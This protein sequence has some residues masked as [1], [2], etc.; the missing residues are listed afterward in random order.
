MRNFRLGWEMGK[1]PGTGLGN[2][3][4]PLFPS[5]I[6]NHSTLCIPSPQI[7]L[8]SDNATAYFSSPTSILYFSSSLFT[9]HVA[10]WLHIGSTHPHLAIVK[11]S[12][13]G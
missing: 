11:R 1:I 3:F 9:H 4:P 13:I 5:P 6:T 7:H 8:S 2:L 12:S 10:W